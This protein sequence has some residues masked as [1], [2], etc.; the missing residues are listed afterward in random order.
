MDHSGTSDPYVKLHLLPGASKVCEHCTE[1]C[2]H[3]HVRRLQLCGKNWRNLKGLHH[4]DFGAF[5]Y[6]NN[7]PDKL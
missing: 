7:V 5:I 3:E 6:A 1:N 2:I 4:D